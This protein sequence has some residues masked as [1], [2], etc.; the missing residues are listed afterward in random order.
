MQQ[1]THWKRG[2]ALAL[3]TAIAWG[4]LPLA[5]KITLE[6]LDPYTITWFRFLTA[7]LVLAGILAVT[8]RL[9][10]LG[11]L[12]GRAWLIFGVAL[13]GLVGNQPA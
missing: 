5:L 12:D 11:S 9:P 8:R 10:S 1:V 13:S 6:V 3:V 2:F 7:A 4:L